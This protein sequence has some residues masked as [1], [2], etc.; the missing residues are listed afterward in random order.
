MRV[1]LGYCYS[2]F[3]VCAKLYPYGSTRRVNAIYRIRT[4]R[5][6]A[7]TDNAFTTSS[8]VIGPVS[9]NFPNWSR[10]EKCINPVQETFLKRSFGKFSANACPAARFDTNVLNAGHSVRLRFP[11]NPFAP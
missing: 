8:R 9:S 4:R 2:S 3:S 11:D 1:Y 6:H 7:P 5:V 10:K